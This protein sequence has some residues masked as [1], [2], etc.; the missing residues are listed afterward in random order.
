MRHH[1]LTAAK[2]IERVRV[3]V[4]LIVCNTFAFPATL[5]VACCQ[6][7]FLFHF[8]G[9][10]SLLGTCCCGFCCCCY[11]CSHCYLFAVIWLLACMWWHAELRVWQSGLNRFIEKCGEFFK[12]RQINW[13]KRPTV[14]YIIYYTLGIFKK[15]VR[16]VEGV[17]DDIQ[18]F[19]EL[20][21]KGM[22]SH[23]IVW[24]FE[25]CQRWTMLDLKCSNWGFFY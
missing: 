17:R 14:Q 10:F 11:C 25:P 5:H 12:S 1:N 18:Y 9:S 15:N 19:F 16:A 7:L 13:P 24:L 8:I 6:W 2:L 22:L 3:R 20:K 23:L 21:Y 4:V